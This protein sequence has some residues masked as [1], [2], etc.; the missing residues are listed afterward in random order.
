[1]ACAG[2]EV[3]DKVSVAFYA[4][5]LFLNITALTTIL[6]FPHIFRRSSLSRI[7]TSIHVYDGVNSF[8]AVIAYNATSGSFLCGLDTAGA[9][10][11]QLCSFAWVTILCLKLGII[12]KPKATFGH[13]Q[14]RVWDHIGT[15]W[16]AHAVIFSFSFLVSMLPLTQ[17]T[18][19]ND[20]VS[21][22][23]YY[24]GSGSKTRRTWEIMSFTVWGVIATFVSTVA[25]IRAYLHLSRKNQD[26]VP[27]FV[28]HRFQ[29]FFLYPISLFLYFWS[30]DIKEYVTAYECTF[31]TLTVIQAISTVGYTLAFW[32]IFRG[33]IQAWR[34]LLQDWWYGE[35]R[36][37]E[38]LEKTYGDTETQ[39]EASALDSETF[40]AAEGGLPAV[41]KS[42]SRAS[43]NSESPMHAHDSTVSVTI[44]TER[45]ERPSRSSARPSATSIVEVELKSV[46]KKSLEIQGK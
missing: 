33:A 4:F 26:E 34:I 24:S 11:M 36:M 1:M 3:T 5:I 45:S 44:K 31:A 15:F 28:R 38:Y 43:I 27:T 37:A 40:A 32:L 41:R 29:Y 20:G 46:S 30:H 2:S 9:N 7:I 10:T 12:L 18:V 14:S 16:V 6:V 42:Q 39:L 22:F 23:C 13:F 17:L 19:S 21:A 8:I 35:N 25:S